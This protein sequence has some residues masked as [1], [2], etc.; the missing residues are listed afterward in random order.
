MILHA[1]IDDHAAVRQHPDIRR[2][3]PRDDAELALHELR[4]AVTALLRIE[5]KSDADPAA[6]RLAGALPLADCRQPDRVARRLKRGDVIAGIELQSGGGPVGQLCGRDDVLPP[7]IEGLSLQLERHLIDQSFDCKRRAGSCDAAVRPVRRLVSGDGV[8][9]EL[10]VPDAIGPGQVARG[11]ARLLERAGGPQR[12][13]AGIDVDIAFE[14][15]QACRRDP[16]R[17]SDHRCDRGNG[18]MRADALADPRSIAPDALTFIAMAATATSS[19]MMRFLPPK[20]PPTSGAITRTR[21]S[22]MP[23]IR[24]SAMRLTCPPCVDR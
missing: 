22:G 24:D 6:V 17:W 1:D 7:Q 13:G 10:Q 21:S 5:G 4:G 18:P 19:G 9:V 15:E 16:P 20:P 23:S 14:P 8:G 3:V 11:H 12:I 2:F